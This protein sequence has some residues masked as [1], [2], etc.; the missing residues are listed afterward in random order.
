MT[1]ILYFKYKNN[2]NNYL[3]VFR[4]DDK[5]HLILSCRDPKTGRRETSIKK[6]VAHF[7]DVNG[8][9]VNEIVETEVSKMHN[10][11]LSERKEK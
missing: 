10:S 11:L 3:F 1:I 9:V 2:L 7:I 4:Y 6:S 5:Y 8:I